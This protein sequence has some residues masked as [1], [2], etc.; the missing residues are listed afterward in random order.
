VAGAGAGCLSNL[1]PTQLF[2][3][4]PRASDVAANKSETLSQFL[5]MN[6]QSCVGLVLEA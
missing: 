6:T 3:A 2:L 5:M 1:V 4:E